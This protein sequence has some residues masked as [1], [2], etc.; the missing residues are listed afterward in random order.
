MV[1]KFMLPLAGLVAVKRPG[2]GHPAGMDVVCGPP[3]VESAGEESG[4]IIWSPPA[5]QS[6]GEESGV[7][8]WS[9]PAVQS[10]G[11]ES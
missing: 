3:A 10:A 2:V 6:A 9:P 8:I 7:I 1:S 4:V 5:V 11:E